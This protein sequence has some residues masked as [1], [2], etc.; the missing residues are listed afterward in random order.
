MNQDE[1][2]GREQ[3]SDSPKLGFSCYLYYM[4]ACLVGLLSR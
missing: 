2:N 1:R 4:Y 3:A